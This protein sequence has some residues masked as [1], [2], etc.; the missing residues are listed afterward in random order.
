MGFSPSIK[1]SLVVGVVGLVV[2]SVF[3]LQLVSLSRDE[4]SSSMMTTL[5]DRIGLI[6]SELGRTN[7][8]NELLIQLQKQL[9][10]ELKSELKVQDGKLNEQKQRIGR[11]LE[12]INALQQKLTDTSAQPQ[13]QQ[14]PQAPVESHH[15]E[16]RDE[17]CPLCA[18]HRQ[19]KL[20]S[21]PAESSH[22]LAAILQVEYECKKLTTF[23]GGGG[24]G[25]GAWTI[26]E[27]FFRTTSDNK[28]CLVY[29]FGINNEFSFDN[30]M[31]NK[32]GC[33]L[34]CFDPSMGWQ[35]KKMS[36]RMSFYNLG[37]AGKN[38]V[39]H[40]GWKLNSLK[41][42]Q[43]NLGL[44]DRVVEVLKVDTEGAEW[45]AIPD[46]VT[47]GALDKVK[48]FIFE[49]HFWGAHTPEQHRQWL[50]VINMLRDKGFKLYYSHENPQSTAENLGFLKQMSCCYEISFIRPD[51]I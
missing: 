29:S 20:G 30:D 32:K 42:I 8:Q 16:E 12:Q 11:L 1:S 41:T 10:S 24:G 34:H 9:H 39:N 50:D 36:E 5:A 49:I 48:Q 14:Q 31:M 7:G 38:Y 27:D 51:M 35:D 37:I 4:A 2:V 23:G 21:L 18:Y 25:D 19:R 46:M 47:S 40:K 3:I 22:L 43:K 33:E 45:E 6:S 26:C 13:V 17:K 28:P 44:E 15:H